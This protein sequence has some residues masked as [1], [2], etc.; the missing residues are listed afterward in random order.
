MIKT[1]RDIR[2][3]VLLMSSLGCLAA[4]R[5]IAEV[6]VQLNEERQIKNL[7]MNTSGMHAIYLCLYII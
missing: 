2:K 5:H 3:H 1:F 4:S 7:L 6:T